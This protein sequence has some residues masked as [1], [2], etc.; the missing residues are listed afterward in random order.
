MPENPRY[1]GIKYKVFCGLN[2][3]QGND[4]YQNNKQGSTTKDVGYLANQ[5]AQGISTP[6]LK[7]NPCWILRGGGDEWV[8]K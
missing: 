3:E 4:R 8:W 5:A 7:Y 2:F 1:F 6:S